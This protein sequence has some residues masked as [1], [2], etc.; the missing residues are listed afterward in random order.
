M[1]RAKLR[2]CDYHMPRFAIDCTSPFLL[3]PRENMKYFVLLQ[4]VLSHKETRTCC[5]MT[6]LYEIWERQADRY[7]EMKRLTNDNE[8][9]I[10]SV[11]EEIN[12]VLTSENTKLRREL[13]SE[14]KKI[15]ELGHE[16]VSMK[17]KIEKILTTISLVES[18]ISA[19][20]V[21]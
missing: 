8:N 5:Q 11:E 9:K 19:I 14:A 17:T 21:A 20:H 13:K 2:V 3:T 10:K 15:E 6:Q 7:Y 16:L 12:D 4:L 1:T 18:L